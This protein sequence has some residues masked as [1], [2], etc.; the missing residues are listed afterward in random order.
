MEK[1]TKQIESE[2]LGYG[3]R[4][5]MKDQR[6]N[7]LSIL[8]WEGEVR[9]HDTMKLEP[10]KHVYAVFR[11]LQCTSRKRPRLL[12]L[13]N[14]DL[15]WYLLLL[16]SMFPRTRLPFSLS[17]MHGDPASCTMFNSSRLPT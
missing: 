6:S 2:T 11:E 15:V 4:M 8:P 10:V 1:A 7:M 13:G 3:K 16:E 5:A 9:R 17:V 14:N 12:S